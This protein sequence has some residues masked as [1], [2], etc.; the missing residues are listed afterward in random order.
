M[1]GA[2]NFTGGSSIAETQTRDLRN[3]SRARLPDE[4]FTGMLHHILNSITLHGAFVTEFTLI[5]AQ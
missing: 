2:K 1:R 5:E 4:V 3:F